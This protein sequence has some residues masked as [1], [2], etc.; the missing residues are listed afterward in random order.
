MNL[1]TE[2]IQA[3]NEVMK[4][5]TNL[6]KNSKV[7]KGRNSYNGTKDSDVKEVFNKSLSDNGLVM[8]PVDVEKEE[9]QID[10]WEEMDQY[11]K[12]MKTKQSV[13]TK[14]ITKYLLAHTSG[15]FIYVKGYGHGVDSQDK[16]AGKATTYAMKNAL[17]YSFLTPVKNIDDTDTT[18]SDEISAPRNQVNKPSKEWLNPNTDNWNKVVS[19]LNGGGNISEVEKKYSISKANRDSLLEQS[20]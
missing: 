19:Y 15:Q 11:S 2:I 7:G 3:I 20:V 14:V 6:E 1:G 10:R 4:S 9:T 8:L 16:G 18:H 13:F 5:V 12:E 17:L